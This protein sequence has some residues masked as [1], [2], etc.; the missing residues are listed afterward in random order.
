MGQLIVLS[1]FRKLHQTNV[2]FYGKTT[3]FQFPDIVP[4]DHKVLVIDFEYLDLRK[5]VF[6]FEFGAE[7]KHPQSHPVLGQFLLLT[8]GG[9]Y[10]EPGGDEDSGAD[11]S[12]NILR[13]I[14]T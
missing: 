2:I 4:V 6:V 14:Y 8:V 5:T 12:V 11:P 13:E 3:I 9:C 1:F 7:V 10:K